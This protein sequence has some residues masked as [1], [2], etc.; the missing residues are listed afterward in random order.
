MLNREAIKVIKFNVLAMNWDKVL[1]LA[2]EKD[3]RTTSNLASQVVITLVKNKEI[4]PVFYSPLAK[5]YKLLPGD[6]VRRLENLSGSDFVAL[7]RGLRKKATAMEA[8]KILDSV[9]VTQTEIQKEVKKPAPKKTVSKAL[10][11][12]L[13]AVVLTGAVVL[14]IT[15]IW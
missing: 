5:K 15:L 11:Y 1:E 9:T 8:K 12:A 3:P 10:L 6:M 2:K 13:F 4:Y 14:L 7:Y